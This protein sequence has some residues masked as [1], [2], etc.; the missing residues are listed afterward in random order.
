MFLETFD[1]VAET[2]KLFFRR[3]FNGGQARIYLLD[4]AG[5]WTL[6]RVAA[7]STRS[8]SFRGASRNRSYSFGVSAVDFKDRESD[9]ALVLVP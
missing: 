1:K 3:L 6:L 8:F 9:K 4:E 2:F 7:L 5:R